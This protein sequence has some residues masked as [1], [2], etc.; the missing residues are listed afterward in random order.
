MDDD[1]DPLPTINPII[2]NLE[3]ESLPL[4]P[5]PLV[6]IAFSVFVPQ[7]GYTC[8]FSATPSKIFRITAAIDKHYAV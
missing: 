7:P 8:G 1:D 3:G 5:N 6:S 2:I 4:A